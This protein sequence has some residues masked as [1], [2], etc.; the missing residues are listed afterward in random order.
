MNGTVLTRGSTL[1][2]NYIV[3]IALLSTA[4]RVQ[5]VTDIWDIIAAHTKEISPPEAQIQEL[6]QRLAAYHQNPRAGA[7]WQ[8]VQQKVRC[9]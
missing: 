6:D 9:L 8:E 7:T 3:E 4:E 2:K 5:L 1:T